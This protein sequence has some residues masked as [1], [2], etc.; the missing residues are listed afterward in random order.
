MIKVTQISLNLLK[1]ALRN[2][3]LL[4]FRTTAVI[5]IRT[6]QPAY[7]NRTI[8]RARFA[9]RSIILHHADTLLPADNS[10]HTII[11]PVR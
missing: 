9:E 10:L 8:I 4:V 11:S 3:D 2:E 7:H 6:K 1:M 5:Q